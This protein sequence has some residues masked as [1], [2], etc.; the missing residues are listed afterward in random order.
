VELQNGKQDGK[1]RKM[2]QLH[3]ED[4]EFLKFIITLFRNQAILFTKINR[5]ELETLFKSQFDL[6]KTYIASIDKEVN[7]SAEITKL[8]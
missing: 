5:D 3:K 6:F 7:K 4:K 8:Q 1:M 2:E